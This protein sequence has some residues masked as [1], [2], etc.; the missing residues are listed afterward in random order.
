MKSADEVAKIFQSGTLEEKIE[1]EVEYQD[2]TRPYL[3]WAH[4]V[5]APTERNKR[6]VGEEVIFVQHL[7]ACH[8]NLE[9]VHRF[10]RE[11][12]RIVHA[13]LPES[14]DSEQEERLQQIR[15]H[16]DTE[17]MKEDRIRAELEKELGVQGKMAQRQA[18]KRVEETG[19]NG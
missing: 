14:K 9:T 4:I 15:R 11:G 2:A 7:D 13:N 6:S 12:K 19:A 8:S 5:N 1:C 18:K 3:I 17:K 10:E 16:C